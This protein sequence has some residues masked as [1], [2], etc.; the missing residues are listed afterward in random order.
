MPQTR[1]PAAAFDVPRAP[2]S[3][4][5]PIDYPLENALFSLMWAPKVPDLYSVGQ[6]GPKGKEYFWLP[7]RLQAQPDTVRLECP[8]LYPFKLV[9]GQLIS[10]IPAESAVAS[11]KDR[12]RVGSHCTCALYGGHCIIQDESGSPR[13]AVSGQARLLVFRLYDIL[14]HRPLPWSRSRQTSLVW[15][16]SA[17]IAETEVSLHS[18]SPS[19]ERGSSRVRDGLQVKKVTI[20]AQFRL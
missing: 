19:R 14:S 17:E 6:T 10:H 15:L 5:R 4:P 13:S 2:F 7:W 9:D 18:P 1:G 12:P 8:T 3:V 20:P 11:E 16:G